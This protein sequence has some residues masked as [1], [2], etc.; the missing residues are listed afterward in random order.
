MYLV[1]F[2]KGVD[3]GLQGHH[4]SQGCPASWTGRFGSIP[5][6]FLG[7]S[8]YLSGRCG[9]SRCVWQH[10]CIA[11]VCHLLAQSILL[12]MKLILSW[13][14]TTTGQYQ[15]CPPEGRCILSLEGSILLSL[16]FCAA[17]FVLRPRVTVM[18]IHGEGLVKKRLLEDRFSCT[19]EGTEPY[20]T[21]GQQSSGEGF[22]NDFLVVPSEQVGH[23]LHIIKKWEVALWELRP[24]RIPCAECRIQPEWLHVSFWS[25][26]WCV[27]KPSF[28]VSLC[29][30]Q[31]RE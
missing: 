10:E 23:M 7:V 12:M 2:N 14:P 20:T 26:P 9:L 22:E 21:R 4:N 16:P 11:T 17:L 1:L 18:A 5:S 6:A 13:G 8:R 27:F 29:F 28:Q 19:W 31:V 30:S 15:P 3:Q 25:T 24:G